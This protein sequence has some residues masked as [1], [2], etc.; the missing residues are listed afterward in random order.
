MIHSPVPATSTATVGESLA[1]FRQ[2]HLTITNGRD[3]ERT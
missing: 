2:L 1:A 3:E